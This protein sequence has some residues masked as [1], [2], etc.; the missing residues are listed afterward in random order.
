MCGT[1]LPDICLRLNTRSATQVGESALDVNIVSNDKLVLV[2]DELGQSR[3][4][5]AP[6]VDRYP[7]V[8]GSLESRHAS[9][10]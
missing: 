7:G 6:T 3:H 2:L 4:L 9:Y 10:G 1:A 5:R 8:L